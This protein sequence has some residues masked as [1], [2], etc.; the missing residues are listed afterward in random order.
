MPM[1]PCEQAAAATL[2]RLPNDTNFL[3]PKARELFRLADIRFSVASAK[4]LIR[5]RFHNSGSNDFDKLRDFG[6][7]VK[8]VECRNLTILD[9]L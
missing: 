8:I 7:W 2:L 1:P 4:G 6:F 9:F 3:R 5:R